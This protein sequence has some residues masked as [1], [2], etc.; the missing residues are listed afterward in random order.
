MPPCQF[1]WERTADRMVEPVLSGLFAC[2]NVFYRVLSTEI[3]GVR[4]ELPGSSVF[5]P[6]PFCNGFSA[7]DPYDK[8]E[9]NVYGKIMTIQKEY[10]K[11]PK[12]S[13]SITYDPKECVV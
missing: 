2:R 9:K 7:K 8:S 11:K 10:R 1:A 13:G 3:S 4:V 5:T 12:T 6:S